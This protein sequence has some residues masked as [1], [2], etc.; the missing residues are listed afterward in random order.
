MQFQYDESIREKDRVKPMN[1]EKEM[2]E[3]ETK[4]KRNAT[5]T[6][7]YH[8]KIILRKSIHVEAR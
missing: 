3:N 7:Q 6:I 1:Q 8:R 4:K 2:K 5:K